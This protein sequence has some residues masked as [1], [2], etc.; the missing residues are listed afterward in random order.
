MPCYF[1]LYLSAFM[2]CFIL[3][4]KSII[5]QKSFDNMKNAQ[6]NPN[7]PKHKIHIANIAIYTAFLNAYSYSGGI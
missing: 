4:S 2:V 6:H 1:I 7:N 3:V 5:A